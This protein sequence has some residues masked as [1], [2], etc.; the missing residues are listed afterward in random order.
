[1]GLLPE[2]SEGNQVGCGAARSQWDW[3]GTFDL[4][5]LLRLS[6]K[7]LTTVRTTCLYT[8]SA[9]ASWRDGEREFLTLAQ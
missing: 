5:L 4:L 7:L 1:M 9:L 3:G 6:T 2:A 8:L